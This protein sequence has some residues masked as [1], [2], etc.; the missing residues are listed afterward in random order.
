MI[1]AG[2]KVSDL[3][4]L[5]KGKKKDSVQ[6]KLK[7][8]MLETIPKGLNA[9]DNIDYEQWSSENL[10]KF[11]VLY[12]I[13]YLLKNKGEYRF[14]FDKLKT[15]KWDIE[16][17]DSQTENPLA[18]LKDQK[19]WLRFALADL[20]DEIAEYEGEINSYLGLEEHDTLQ[21][22][23]LYE[24]IVGKVSDGNIINKNSV[25]NLTLLD[26]QTNRAYKNSLFPTKR[27]FIIERDK[28]GKFIPPCTKNV[29][30]K[31]YQENTTDLRKWTQADAEE[32]E[33]DIEKTFSD[34]FSG[35]EHD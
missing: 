21:F 8:L 35:V 15:E 12:N 23:D 32:Y 14:P 6:E 24:K 11:Y 18:N 31:Y 22:S 20:K 1:F 16:H 3:Y 10:K 26:S 19:E 4:A 33:R 28:D 7:R 13:L 5:L 25:G 17:I 34:F 9:I 27:R 2:K 30:L 29:F